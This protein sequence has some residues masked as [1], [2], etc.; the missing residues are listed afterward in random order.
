MNDKEIRVLGL[1]VYSKKIRDNYIE[2]KI[3]CN[4]YKTKTY[5]TKKEIELLWLFKYTKDFLKISKFKTNRLIDR[6]LTILNSKNKNF[7]D[8]YIMVNASG[9]TYF[10]M[11]AFQEICK[12]NNSH[13][14]V[15]VATNNFHY[16][17]AKMYVPNIP[18]YLM[19]EYWKLAFQNKK[20]IVKNNHRFFI[21]LPASYYQSWEDKIITNKNLHYYTSFLE[22]FNLRP[23]DITPKYAVISQDI[24]DGMLEK[25]K[26]TGLNLNNFIFISPEAKSNPSLDIEFWEMLKDTLTKIGFDC[27]FNIHEGDLKL[28]NIKHCS[29]DKQEVQALCEYAK[30]IVGIKSGLIEPLC[31]I[32]DIPII[33]IYTS[34]Y[35]R[36]DGRFKPM[37]VENH[38]RACSNKK[39][40]CIDIKNIYEF[41][42]ENLNNEIL[43]SKISNIIKP[44]LQY[45][46]THIVDHCN[47]N[48]KAC[49]HY[50]NVTK[51]NFIK[52]DDFCSDMK[53]LSKKFNIGQIRLMGGEPL[54][55]PNINDF[56]TSTRQYF[57][58]SDIRLVT[59]G[60]LLSKQPESFWETLKITKIKIDLTKYPIEGITF[61]K[62]L[63]AI[64]KHVF[65]HYRNDDWGFCIQENAMGDFWIAAN[66]QLTMDSRGLNNPA[67]AFAKCP[68]KR[69]INLINGKLVHCPTAG[70]LHN[71]NSYFNKNLSTEEGIDIYKNSANE[72]M[73]YLSKPIETCKYCV[74]DEDIILQKWEISK[75]EEDEWFVNKKS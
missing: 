11:H 45:L 32:K 36:L 72:I 67:D 1:R 46:E 20:I 66:F 25:V 18:C 26:K 10:F 19:N 60:I 33:S 28:N 24:R 40:P 38:M 55:A 64:G 42:G 58:N 63:D 71:Y 21:V 15:I 53:E 50:C 56:L 30:G 31:S 29:L 7:D 75:K 39:I 48:C 70:Y 14:P 68:Y 12:K 65:N 5:A 3:I 61:S 9:E 73:D 51:P 13:N 41:D 4:I 2:R 74:V 22:V 59:N 44:Q 54:L 47:L 49:C 52:I 16:T 69:C 43:I 35:A 62:G 23:E 6:L 34:M 27:F 57:P 17:L 8:V 37:T